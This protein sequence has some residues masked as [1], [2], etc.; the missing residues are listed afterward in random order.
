MEQVVYTH[1]L[2]HYRSEATL[3]GSGMMNFYVLLLSLVVLQDRQMIN[4]CYLSD[5]HSN[6][7]FLI[8]TM[9]LAI[10]NEET[11]VFYIKKISTNESYE[12]T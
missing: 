10:E 7:G 4:L 8:T 11:H 9:T 5:T 2:N 1:V 3:F 12:T 6:G